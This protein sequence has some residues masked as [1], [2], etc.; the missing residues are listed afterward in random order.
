MQRM[1]ISSPAELGK[2]VDR[3]D[4]TSTRSKI[5]PTGTKPSATSSP[6]RQI[7]EIEPR[8]LRW[9]RCASRSISTFT[10]PLRPLQIPPAFA[11]TQRSWDHDEATVYGRF[12]FPTT[13]K[14][15]EL[16]EYNADT[17]TS[18]LEAVIQ[19]Y[20]MQDVFP[21]PISS[22]RSTIADRS[23]KI[24]GAAHAR[25]VWFTSISGNV[26]DFM[27]V[28]YLRDTAIQAGLKTTYI[29]VERIGW[30]HDRRQFVDENE[31]H[32]ST[33]FKLYP[34]EWMIRE[35]FGEKLLADNTYWLESPWKMLLSNKAI[36]PILW[37]LYP[38]SPYLLPASFEPMA[39]N[40]VRKPILSREGANIQIVSGGKKLLETDG[41]Y[42]RPYVYQKY[43]PLPN[44]AGFIR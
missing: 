44:I 36:L 17:P 31:R 1:T 4:S 8:D 22:T 7:D 40:F 29:E 33:V 39:D 38:E 28:N 6:A 32:M 18:L 13:A 24:F 16:L 25:G 5:S 34:W 14:R 21:T 42:G 27:T 43:C 11:I 9:T 10:T 26:E 15:P 20:W 3:R 19:W 41:I 35:Q 23:W 30:N 2:I 12:D 37:E